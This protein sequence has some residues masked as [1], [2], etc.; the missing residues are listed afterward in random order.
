[1]V[2]IM[3]R[4]KA[5]EVDDAMLSKVESLAAQGLTKEQIARSLGVSYNTLNERQKDY[6][7]FL[8]AIKRGQAKGIATVSNALFQKAKDGDNTAMIFYLKNRDPDNWEDI[9]KRQ[10]LGD[11]DNPIEHRHALFE[12]NPVGRDD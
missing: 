1:M 9:Q 4:P 3:G 8:E 2:K 12:F 6:P 10:H 5:F 7:E 11:P